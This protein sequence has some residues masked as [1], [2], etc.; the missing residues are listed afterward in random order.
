MFPIISKEE[1]GK[2]LQRIM[3]ERGI[4]VK[5]VQEFLYLGC[6]QSVYHWLDGSSIPS[7]DNLYA[8]SVFFDMPIDAIVRGNR[9]VTY[10]YISEM[11]ASEISEI[12]E[13]D[14]NM[15]HLRGY[16]EELAA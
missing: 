3:A 7:L 15:G 12:E 5:E 13:D 9:T 4:T 8:L 6:P 10:S 16:F 1:T 11:E 2:N 14:E